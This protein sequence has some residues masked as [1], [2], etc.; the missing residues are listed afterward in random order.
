MAKDQRKL[1]A[2]ILSPQMRPGG[3]GEE[4]SGFR[5]AQEINNVADATIVTMTPP[6]FVGHLSDHFPDARV[7][8]CSPWPTHRLHARLNSL[9]KPNY[10]NY[11]FYAKRII[12]R[13]LETEQFDI[14]HQMGPLGLRYP[15][16]LAQFDIPYITGPHAG[17][18]A[19]PQGLKTDESALPWYYGLR[20]IDAFRFRH[21]PML[22]KS[23]ER[24]SAVIGVGEY[25]RNSLVD[26]NLQRFE[27]QP[28]N[29]IET[30][31]HISS[32]PDSTTQLHMLFVG[33]VIRTKGLLY[34]IEALGRANIGTSWQ[35]DVIGVGDDQAECERAALALG[36]AAQVR[37]HGYLPRPEIDQFYRKADLFLF[38]SYR[39][40]SGGVVMEAMS[41]GLPMVL[42]DYGGPTSYV[43]DDCALKVSVESKEALIGGIARAIEQFVHDPGAAARLRERLL[44]HARANHTWSARRS[45]YVDLYE[46]LTAVERSPRLGAA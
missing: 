27:C 11:Y 14:A 18:L 34:A 17:S 19:T 33:R 39:E 10:I 21:D 15:S 45:F 40:P 23:F 9:I 6:G 24:A 28:E 42:A 29:A 37:F 7:F 22:R 2:L 16:P 30:L 32:R 5:L 43:P 1:R 8:E 38:P 25:V 20:N 4:G 13:L 36:I 31:Q 41:F 26:L 35:L 46:Q 44:A 12:T 3:T